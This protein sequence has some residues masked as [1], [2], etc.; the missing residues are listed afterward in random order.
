MAKSAAALAKKP[1]PHSS[2]SSSSA[3]PIVLPDIPKSKIRRGDFVVHQHYGVGLFEGV[4]RSQTFQVLPNGTKVAMKALKIKF[5][6][7]MLEVFPRD[8]AQ[9][10]K[11]FK[12]KEDVEA[13]YETVKLD[14][15]RSR[16]SWQKRKERAAKK[17]SHD[18]SGRRSSTSTSSKRLSPSLFPSLLVVVV[19]TLSSP[20]VP[21]SLALHRCGP[22]PLISSRC[23]RSASS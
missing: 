3:E 23:T 22:S 7:G 10:L 21:G 19:L 12:R 13:S 6:D 1:L 17:V 9:D 16:R 14:G 5:K 8:A 4:F 2:I 15:M 18:R 20:C 11:L